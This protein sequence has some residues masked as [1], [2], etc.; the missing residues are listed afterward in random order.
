MLC[1]MMVARSS[2]FMATL[3]PV[4]VFCANLTLANVPSPIVRPTSYFPTRRSTTMAPLLCLHAT[5]SLRGLAF[6]L[7]TRSEKRRI[8]FGGDLHS[9]GGKGKGGRREAPK[10][11]RWRKIKWWSERE[12]TGAWLASEGTKHSA[13]TVQKVGLMG[14]PVLTNSRSTKHA[15][16]HIVSCGPTKLIYQ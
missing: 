4:S 1:L 12:E 15:A 14:S 5:C 13:R 10:V 3:S 6:S 16:S 2:T 11:F 9:N 8:R 7:T